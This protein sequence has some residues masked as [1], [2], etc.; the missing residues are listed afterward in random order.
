MNYPTLDQVEKAD[1][2]TLAKWYRF[3]KSP[4]DVALHPRNPR[5][6]EIID[7]QVTIMN[8]ITARFNELGGMNSSL[9]KQ[10]GWSREE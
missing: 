9:S 8:R 1:H 10:L 5:Y 7:E 2:F 6:F 4:G 3:L